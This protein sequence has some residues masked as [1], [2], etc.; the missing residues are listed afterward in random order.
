MVMEPLPEGIGPNPEVTRVKDVPPREFDIYSRAADAGVYEFLG[1]RWFVD[2]RVD[3]SL[4]REARM[5]WPNYVPLKCRRIYRTPA[6]T[7]EIHDYYVIGSYVEHPNEAYSDA[8]IKLEYVPPRFPFPPDKI[9]PIQT[10]WAE[11]EKGTP[12]FLLNAPPAPI[13]F[14]RQK[15][16]QMR[17]LRK[18]M[19]STIRIDGNKVSQGDFRAD[20]LNE[21]LRAEKE[22]D[23]RLVEEARAEARYRLRHN[24]AQIKAAIDNERWVPEP[25]SPTPFV[26]L[27]GR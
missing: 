13:R 26:D 16:E 2:D 18:F 3:E 20:K 8:Y 9:Q 17:A 27:G 22:R 10:Q 24:W 6:G 15:V 19:D 1:E 25:P 7:E 23:D 5:A 12:E 14:D 11:W 21:I 4:V